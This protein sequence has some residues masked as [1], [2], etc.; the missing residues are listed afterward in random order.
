MNLDIMNEVQRRGGRFWNIS[1]VAEMFDSP[2]PQNDPNGNAIE[3]WQDLFRTSVLGEIFVPEA[4]EIFFSFSN[5]EE[6]NDVSAMEFVAWQIDNASPEFIY[7]LINKVDGQSIVRAIYPEANE[8]E[9]KQWQE[10]QFDEYWLSDAEESWLNE[11]DSDS[12][13]TAIHFIKMCKSEKPL[14]L[15]FALAECV[16]DQRSGITCADHLEED[17]TENFDARDAYSDWDVKIMCVAKG[18]MF[19]Y[20]EPGNSQ[21]AM[22]DYKV[23]YYGV[24]NYDEG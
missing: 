16:L 13:T 15:A 22:D 10:I 21:L 23:S 3:D 9:P 20:I 1:T 24:R 17:L 4:D 11:Y 12:Y 19:P 7:Y 18:R 14:E 5:S 6:K 8:E 2:L